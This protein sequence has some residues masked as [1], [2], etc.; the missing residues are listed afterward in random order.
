[1]KLVG[2]SLI[3][4]S[5]TKFFFFCRTY[6]ANFITVTVLRRFITM[7]TALLIIPHILGLFQS[8]CNFL[9]LGYQKVKKERLNNFH[10]VQ[11]TLGLVI[12][13]IIIQFIDIYYISN[14][15]LFYEY[16]HLFLSYS[17]H[18]IWA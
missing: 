15:N 1:M 18:L 8:Q 17:F 11:K 14:K 5:C 6:Y 9:K 16:N 12:L 4:F 2:L 13:I 3:V 10:Y 7:I